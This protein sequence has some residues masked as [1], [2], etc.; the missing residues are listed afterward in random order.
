MAHA[1]IR[2][3]DV[4]HIRDGQSIEVVTQH[5]ELGSRVADADA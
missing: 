1:T 2:H 4:A 3:V 5:P